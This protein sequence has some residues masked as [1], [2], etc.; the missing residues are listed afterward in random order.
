MQFFHPNYPGRA[1]T[2]LRFLVAGSIVIVGCATSEELSPDVTALLATPEAGLSDADSMR[3]LVSPEH[4][5]VEQANVSEQ[6]WIDDSR[7]PWDYAEVHYLRGGRIGYSTM[8]V[9]WSEI[10]AFKQLRIQRTDVVDRAPDGTSVP[11][12]EITYEAYERPN[13]E[14]ASLRFFSKVDGKPEMEIE[15]R[16]IFENFEIAKRVED[17]KLQRSKMI[18]PVGSWGPLGIQSALMRNPMEPGQTRELQFYLPQLG[19]FVKARL[20]AI[21]HE[22]TPLAGRSVSELL[23]IEVH[24]GTPETG[25]RSHIWVDSQGIIQKSYTLT[26]EPILRVRVEQDTVRRLADQS[27]FARLADLEIALSGKVENLQL[28][29]LRVEV[30]AIEFDPFSKFLHN[31]RQQKRSRGAGTC[32]LQTGM[33]ETGDLATE[34]NQSTDIAEE[35]HLGSSAIIPSSSILIGEMATLF[36]ADTSPESQ[37][38][39]A[40]ALHSELNRQWTL[41]PSKGEIGST[42][43]AAR[44]RTGGSM[45]CASVLTALLRNQKIPARLVGGLLI[46]EETGKAKFHVWTQAWFGERWNDLDATTSSSVG[47]LYLAMATTAATGENPYQAWLLVLESIREVLDIRVL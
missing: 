25:V 37:E 42:L 39:V 7:L 16:M 22:I 46:D 21:E 32:Q 47:P 10:A 27:R 43:S 20:E 24:I 44:N 34:N 41:Q 14:L 35:S 18:W 26:G 8:T 9:A 23:K 13:G 12:R 19:Q 11:P 30:Q 6:D 31:H 5:I 4:P 17:G 1:A 15:G 2:V 40:A 29:P 36:L 33:V 45:E 38:L 3:D 28:N